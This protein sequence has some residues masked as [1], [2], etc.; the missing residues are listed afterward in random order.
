MK[1]DNLELY[2][3]KAEEARISDAM[4]ERKFSNVYILERATLPLGRAGLSSLL[5]IMVTLIGSA[6]AAI[7]AAFGI[8]FF[9]R[10]LRNERDIEEQ[11]GL[12]V[13]ATIQYYG[14]L[15]PVTK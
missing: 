12:P 7:A 5:L 8:E 3:K 1:K 13:L 2:K 6:G 9:N 15:R 10:T 11:I 14:D 4:D